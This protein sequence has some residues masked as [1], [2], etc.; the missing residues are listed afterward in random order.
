MASVEASTGR[1]DPSQ[2]RPYGEMK[3]KSLTRFQ[4]GD[5]LFA[6]ITPCM[7]NGKFALATNLTNGFGY[8]STEFHVV[9]PTKA[10]LARYLL[11]YLLQQSVRRDAERNMT[12]AVGQRRVPTAYLKSLPVPVPPLAEQERIVNALEDHLS[13]LHQGQE[14]LSAAAKKLDSLLT[15]ALSRSLRSAT[16][17]PLKE[18]LS[19][20]LINGRSVPSREGGFPVLRLT[21]L[22]QGTLDLS[23]FKEGAWTAAEARPYLVAVGDFLVSRGNGSRSLVGRGGI[24]QNV[25]HEVAFPDTMIRIRTMSELLDLNFLKLIWDSRPVRIHIE[26]N[27]RTTAGIYKINQKMI[28]NTPIPY[29]PIQEQRSIVDGL[30]NLAFMVNHLKS[31]LFSAQKRSEHLKSSVMRASFSGALV[32]QNPADEPASVLLERIRGERAAQPKVKRRR[33]SATTFVQEE[34][35]A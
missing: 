29:L 7:E 9:R 5:I 24:A 2:T 25:D 4:E 31:T 3:K 22:R 32:E 21:A 15:S 17:R 20:P 1:L 12:G 18:F 11:P 28:E 27:A 34:L 16:S 33:K 14:Q 13:H 26:S 8:G 6:K 10:V 19:E 30:E 23:A 35:G